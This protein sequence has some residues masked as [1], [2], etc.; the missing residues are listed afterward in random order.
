VPPPAIEPASKPVTRDLAVERP[1][2]VAA[3]DVVNA[4][5]QQAKR[6]VGLFQRITGASRDRREEDEPTVALPAASQPSRT[7]EPSAPREPLLNNLARPAPRTATELTKP[8]QP[9][10]DPLEIPAFLRRQAN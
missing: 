2:P 4:G 9:A 8:S 6:S 7:P 5:R 10:E 3:A 1:D